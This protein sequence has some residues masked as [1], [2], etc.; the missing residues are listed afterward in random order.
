[1]ITIRIYRKP[2]NNLNLKSK[3]L[4]IIFTRNP[5]LG[6]V[7][8]RLAKTVGNQVA[9]NIYRFLLEH[10]KKVTQTLEVDKQVHY[11]VKIRE[12]DI[13][14]P[15]RYNKRLQK[16]ED[17]GKRMAKAFQDGFNEGYTKVVI[18]GS[19]LYDLSTEDIKAAY[20]KLE[21]NEVVIGP[22]T[23]GGYY[24]LGLT[25]MIHELFEDK[26]WG[27]DTVFNDTLA[28]IQ[29]KKYLLLN[30][31]NDVDVYDDIK[32]IDIFNQFI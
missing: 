5:E 19:D 27:T 21:T 22:A 18:I 13:W 25:T 31:K 10:T 12:N 15:A 28:N 7:K 26:A 6:K 24:L 20:D 1:L 30:P 17:L 8:T 3:K 16:G 23:D 32:D 4:L 29:D 11:S 14:E 2:S 9:L